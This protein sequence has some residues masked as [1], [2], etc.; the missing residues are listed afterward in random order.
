MKV[1]IGWQEFSEALG[2]DYKGLDDDA[3]FSMAWEQAQEWLADYVGHGRDLVNPVDPVPVELQDE[4][5]FAVEQAISDHWS[6]E[7][8]LSHNLNID[9][10]VEVVNE[11]SKRG[12]QMNIYE[13]LNRPLPAGIAI[14]NWSSDTEGVTF[15]LKRPFIVAYIEAAYC[16]S[17]FGDEGLNLK[18]MDGNSVAATMRR[19]AECEGWKIGLDLDRW[20]ETRHH[21][22]Y[23][24]LVKVY[25]EAMK[26]V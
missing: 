7:K 17:S 4:V 5:R 11:W 23:Q 25:N 8:V 24:E 12:K 22:T 2:L 9:R 19:I 20:D 21:P 6:I 1:F 16:V 15:M 13:P 14:T 3:A 18:D 26:R 10:L